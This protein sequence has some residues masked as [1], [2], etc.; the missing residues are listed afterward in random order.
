MAEVLA[1]FVTDD[2][3]YFIVINSSG[4][5]WDDVAK[6]FEAFDNAS[7]GDY[8]IPMPEDGTPNGIGVYRGTFPAHANLVDGTYDVIVMQQVAGSPALGDI[9]I[10]VGTFTW[11]GTTL[12]SASTWASSI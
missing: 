4:N 11:D 3:L 12:R 2:T 5:Y 1:G 10:A 7:L 9:A 6:G 8:D